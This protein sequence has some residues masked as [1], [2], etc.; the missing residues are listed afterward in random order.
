[1]SDDSAASTE[2]NRL[3]LLAIATAEFADKGFDGARVDEIAARTRTS[4]RMIYYH[5]G[6]KLGLYRAVLTCAYDGI[7]SAEAAA[8]AS[9]VAP[10]GAVPLPFSP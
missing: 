7:R 8:E 6:G 4:K 1:M 3:D 9:G 5:F 10:T 2:R